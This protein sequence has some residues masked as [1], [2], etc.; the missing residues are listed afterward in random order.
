MI[1]K[2]GS[3]LRTKSANVALP[4]SVTKKPAE[5]YQMGVQYGLRFRKMWQIDG[6]K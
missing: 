5:F 1:F 6:Y 3:A 4:F 2:F